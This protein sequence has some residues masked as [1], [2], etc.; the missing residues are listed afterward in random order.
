MDQAVG[1]TSRVTAWWVWPLVG[2]LLDQ[3]THL[4]KTMVLDEDGTPVD[5]G[6][7][8]VGDLPHPAG[9]AA[10]GGWPGRR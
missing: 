6:R 4:A 7:A 10:V 3:S 1:E 2:A 8:G 5:A 9:P